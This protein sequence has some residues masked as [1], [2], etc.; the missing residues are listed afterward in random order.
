[1][2]V[3]ENELAPRA[4]REEAYR[5]ILTLI[6]Q[7]PL[8]AQLIQLDKQLEQFVTDIGLRAFRNR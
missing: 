4:E 2:E 7:K 5:E 1:M 8:S 3:L 6:D